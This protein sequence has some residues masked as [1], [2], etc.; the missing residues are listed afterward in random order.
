MSLRRQRLL[1]CWVAVCALLLKAAVP[2]LAAT[3]AQSQGV[4][5]ARL[6]SLYGVAT[7]QSFAAAHVGQAHH[8]HHAAAEAGHGGESHSAADHGRDHC[9]LTA[10]VAMAVGQAAPPDAAPCE[11][12]LASPCGLGGDSS[13]ADE[14]ALWAARLAHGPPARA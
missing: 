12:T 7:A 1:T 13:I 14:C 10:V 6:C 4:P 5:V 11:A 3:A 2:L 8:H 9:A